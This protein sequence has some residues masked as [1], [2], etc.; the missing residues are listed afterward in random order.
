[1]NCIVIGA[2][3]AGRPV[4]RLLNHVGHKV[5]ITDGKELKDFHTDFQHHL[6]VMEE[7]GVELDL[8]QSKPDL[9]GFDT[10]YLAP[11][12]PKTAPIY[13]EIEEKG[14]TIFTNEDFGQLADSLINIDIIG[15]TGTAG[16]TSTTHMTGEIFKAAGY[17]IW[18]C[19]SITQNLVSEVIVDGIVKGLPDKSDIA[20]LELPHGTAGLMGELNLKIGVLVNI[21]DDHLSE[22]GGSKEKYIERKMFITK[23]S[24]SFITSIHCKDIIKDIR[25]D[26]IFYSMVSDLPDYNNEKYDQYFD[27]LANK[28]KIAIGENQ[29][30]NFIAGSPKKAI[31]IGYCHKVKDELD[32]GKF[33]SDFHMVSYYYENGLAATAI[34]MT[35]GIDIEDI[36]KGLANFKG[37][38]AHMEYEGEFKGR[39]VFF[40]CS[41]IL[42]GISSTLEF[43][44]D[45]DLVI[46]LDNFDTLT[47]R[48]KIETGALIGKYAKVMIATGFSEVTQKVEME[49]AY[50]LLE[51]AKDSDAIKVTAETIEEGAELCFKYSKPGDTILHIGPQLAVDALGVSEKIRIG[52]KEG[53]KK[54]D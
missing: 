45:R 8:G 17:N 23:H 49:A 24:E 5:K 12:I 54:Y 42:E 28:E 51:G 2:G 53:M 31:D 36:K 39:E 46:L 6:K 43:L 18:L 20:I 48:D 25:K 33:T 27:K 19:S 16:K 30:V 34:A 37:I 22:F 4:A 15:I 11:S 47:E 32:S 9:D 29:I 3:N 44:S 26:A 1:M 50:E 35:Y 13:K 10:I 52:L 38:S 21:Y 40:D 41:F 7:E 14:L